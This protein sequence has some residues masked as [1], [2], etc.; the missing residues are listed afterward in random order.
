MRILVVDDTRA[1]HA[2]IKTLFMDTGHELDH[3][4]SGDEAIEHLLP[5]KKADY[6]LILLDWEMPGR[7]GMETLKELRSA[8]VET[9]VVMVTTRNHIKDIKK[10]LEDGASEY[11]LKPFTKEILFAKLSKVVGGDIINA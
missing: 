2:F 8:G 9:P 7:D 1:V 11:V 4:Y 5:E 6:G 3:C 10:A